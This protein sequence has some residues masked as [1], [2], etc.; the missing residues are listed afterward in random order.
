MLY[1]PRA[2]TKRFGV[3]GVILIGVIHNDHS[4]LYGRNKIVSQR[5]ITIMTSRNDHIGL[6]VPARIQH[7]LFNSRP[8]ITQP[9]DFQPS[10]MQAHDQYSMIGSKILR[11][12]IGQVEPLDSSL[13]RQ[14]QTPE[15]L[16][17]QQSDPILGCLFQ[18][19]PIRRTTS[20]LHRQDHLPY[21]K[22]SPYRMAA[23]NM[24]TIRVGEDY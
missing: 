8:G 4:G 24:P 22:L 5:E 6:E 20:P 11:L 10:P 12:R 21:G 17:L 23:S 1:L 2:G 19:V 7:R 13:L 14:W 3:I 9:Q 15:L 18:P 16:G